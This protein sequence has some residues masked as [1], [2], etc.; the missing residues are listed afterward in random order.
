MYT[1]SQLTEDLKN[2][3]MYTTI[4]KTN[5]EKLRKYISEKQLDIDFFWTAT[6]AS[7]MLDNYKDIHNTM[8]LQDIYSESLDIQGEELISRFKVINSEYCKQTDEMETLTPTLNNYFDIIDVLQNC[9]DSLDTLM[10]TSKETKNEIIKI[11]SSYI[12]KNNIL[13][14]VRDEELEYIDTLLDI[15]V[16]IDNNMLQTYLNELEQKLDELNKDEEINESPRYLETGVETFNIEP[17]KN[18]DG[19][20]DL[21]DILSTMKKNNKGF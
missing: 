6:E 16:N 3:E 5:L 17:E 1:K 21:E 15:M 4:V 7:I 9:L 14:P 12:I 11:V 19:Y 13:P 8:K 18:N 2:L 20:E 10:P